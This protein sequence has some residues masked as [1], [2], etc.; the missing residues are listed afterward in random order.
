MDRH[1]TGITDS[2]KIHS[3]L[4]VFFKIKSVHSFANR[5]GSGS[6]IGRAYCIVAETGAGESCS[7]ENDD[8]VHHRKK[9]LCGFTV[10]LFTTSLTKVRFHACAT[11]RMASTWQLQVGV[12]RLNPYW[13][14][15][16]NTVFVYQTSDFTCVHKFEGHEK[17][18]NAIAWSPLSQYLASCSDDKT[19]RVWS[20]EKVSGFGYK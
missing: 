19:I 12:F 5:H 6:S 18:V 3:L 11:R 14:A 2:L 1:L 13:I 8:S 4:S 17:G 20:M 10:F 7:T 9:T 15:A 16:G